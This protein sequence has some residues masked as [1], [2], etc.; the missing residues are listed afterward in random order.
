M[1]I[2]GMLRYKP[3]SHEN[4]DALFVVVKKPWLDLMILRPLIQFLLLRQMAGIQKPL[5]QEAT[6]KEDGSVKMAILGMQ[7]QTTEPK[8]GDVLLAPKPGLTQI[9]QDLCISLITL[10][11]ECFK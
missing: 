8:G 10:D 1:A 3:D 5:P 9:N 2:L 7:V 4:S 11:L 6:R